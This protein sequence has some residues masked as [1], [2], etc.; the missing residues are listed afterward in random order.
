MVLMPCDGHFR[1]PAQAHMISG[2]CGICVDHNVM[3]CCLLCVQP[4][5]GVLWTTSARPGCHPFH[6]G[7]TDMQQSALLTMFTYCLQVLQVLLQHDAPSRYMQLLVG[8]HGCTARLLLKQE[9]TCS[10]PKLVKMCIE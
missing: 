4:D 9:R 2:T 8:L 3:S 5:H 6:V 10:S 1:M 7:L